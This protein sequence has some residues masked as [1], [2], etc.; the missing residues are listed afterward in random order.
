MKKK[1]RSHFHY[2][3]MTKDGRPWGGAI[4]TKK[5]AIKHRNRTWRSINVAKITTTVEV[6]NEGKLESGYE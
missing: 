1:I 4:A 3:L 5:E 2:Q 6:V